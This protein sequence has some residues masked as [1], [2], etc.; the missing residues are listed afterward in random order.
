[1]QKGVGCLKCRGT[2]YFGQT[3]VFEIMEI[4]DEMRPLIH[5]NSGTHVIREAAIKA[6][7]QT[8]RQQALEKMR[9]GVTTCEEVLRV[10]G[11]LRKQKPHHFKTTIDLS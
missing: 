4:T 1:M 11:G 2:G 10:T 5:N 9:A 7:M 8:L 3:A 6:G